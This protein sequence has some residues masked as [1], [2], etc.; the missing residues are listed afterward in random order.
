MEIWGKSKTNKGDVITL[1]EHIN[2]VL[3]VLEHYKMNIKSENVFRLTE[4]AVKY[5]DLG[6]VLPYF[7][8]KTLGNK[9]YEPFDVYAIIPH[10]LLSVLLINGNHLSK[11]INKIVGED[12]GLVYQNIVLSAI[13]YHHW[14]ES[15]YDIIEGFSDVFEN[16][17]ELVN[18]I[19]KWNK[20]ISNL[21]EL[22]K[23]IKGIDPDSLQI[24]S[25][26]LLGLTNGIK[27]SDYFTPPY[28]LYRLPD[29]VKINQKKLNDWVLISG[30]TMLSDHYASFVEQE[31][32]ESEKKQYLKI[33]Y[34]KPESFDVVKNKF[35]KILKDKTGEL[36]DEKNIWQINKVDTFR[37]NN[38]ILLA[39]TGMGKTEFAFLWSAGKKFFYTL[40]LRSAVNQI[41]D[42]TK[43][44][45]GAENS[46]ILHSDADIYIYGDGGESE[47]MKIY[48]FS[49]QLTMAANISTGDQFFP[50]AL[51]PP[52]YEKIF[53][54]FSYSNLIIDE[55]QA[56][57][58][59]A[60]AIVVKFTEHIVQMGSRFLLMTATL[61]DFIRDEINKRIGIDNIKTLDLFESDPN[62]K[63]FEKHKLNILVDNF[64]DKK[65]SYNQEIINKITEKAKENSGQ[66]VLVVLNT[67]KQAQQVYGDILKTK[68]N[69]LNV[70]LFHSRYSFEHRKKIEN[71]LMDFMGNTPESRNDKK[72]KI[73]IATQV[74]EAS[75]DLDADYLFTELAPWDSLIQ[76]MGR[77]LRE[78]RPN[79]K[80]IDKIIKIRYNT[81]NLPDNVFVLIYDGK[82]S[83]GKTIY[84]SGANYVYSK[85]ILNNALYLLERRTGDVEKEKLLKT[86]I[87]YTFKSSG[88]FKKYKKSGF[89]LNENLKNILVRKNYEGLDNESNYLK[90]FYD[91]LEILDAGFMSER[92]SEAQHIFREINSV[93][94][95]PESRKDEFFNDINNFDFNKKHPYT[96]FKKDIISKFVVN[97]QRYKVEEFLY[98][99]NTVATQLSLSSDFVSFNE[100]AKVM[101]KLKNWLWGYYFAN[102][103]YSENK[104]LTGIIKEESNN[105]F[106]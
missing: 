101:K 99:T 15:F 90:R 66:R 100:E 97:V 72:P 50:Y 82:N 34:K 14:R 9:N 71:E 79:T 58:P 75:L 89:L 77:V 57:D 3:L 23:S 8:I 32:N 86:S 78:L 60:A 52:A 62:L 73:L 20:I 88:E 69:T 54:K 27:F 6:K 81:D 59:K 48:D 47:S 70:K 91:M 29:R 39:P 65:L 18:N 55:I 45:F 37:N 13:A 10:S 63:T 43:N 26:I 30:F 61:P 44:I 22:G 56:Y 64:T 19:S 17:L 42:R 35:I 92:K 85:D 31:Y 105:M 21:N 96:R 104:G 38:T 80:N 7:Q 67:I 11:E 1:Q 40:P 28:Q 68:D 103:E 93:G 98:D 33:T 102:V 94:I 4:L 12:I 51:R 5:H 2:D 106:L 74:V 25:D 76:R 53:A 95:I 36:I 84:E 87:N 49:R 46:G 41:Y 83:K 24:N 16:F